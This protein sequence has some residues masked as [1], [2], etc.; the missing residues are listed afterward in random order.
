M[1]ENASHST[2]TNQNQSKM[3]FLYQHAVVLADQIRI[4]FSGLDQ[5]FNL[6]NDSTSKISKW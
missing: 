1:K 2:E 6:I 5:E 3:I 4:S